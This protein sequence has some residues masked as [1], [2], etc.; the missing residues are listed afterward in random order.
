MAE[1]KGTVTCWKCQKT[2]GELPI[3]VGFREACLHCGFDLHTCKG[4]RFYAPGKPND[5]SIFGTDPIR[6]REA[7]NFCEEFQIKTVHFQ[8]DTSRE[9]ARRILNIEKDEIKPKDFRSLF[10][11]EES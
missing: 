10:P 1:L 4:C 2:I 8:A 5:C 6:D 11:D 3:K 9:N 7:A